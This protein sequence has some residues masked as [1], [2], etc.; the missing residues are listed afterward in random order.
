MTLIED[1][2]QQLRSMIRLCGRLLFRLAAAT[3]EG[4]VIDRA[5]EFDH[6]AARLMDTHERIRRS[7]ILYSGW[8]A[9]EAFLL[10]SGI[11]ST[12]RA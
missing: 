12:P 1:L 10:A 7:A 6:G 3:V 2:A 4:D 9:G 8:M 11:G 5:T